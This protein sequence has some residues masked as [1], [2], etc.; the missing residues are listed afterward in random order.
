MKRIHVALALALASFA[1]AASAAPLTFDIDQPHSQVGFSIRHFFSKVPGQFKDFSGTIVMDPDDPLGLFGRGHDP[2]GQHL[3]RQR[4]ARQAPQGPGLLRRGLVPDADLQE[5][6]GRPRGQGQVKVTGDLTMRGV[7]KSVVLDVEFL[8]MGEVGV[9]GQ[10]MGHQG[11]LRR[12]HD[13]QPQGLRHQ[14]EQDARPGRPDARRRRGH[15]PAHR[16]EPE[17]ARQ[18]EVDRPPRSE[19]PVFTT[20]AFCVSGRWSGRL[21]I[22]WPRTRRPAACT[23]PRTSPPRSDPG[24][25]PA[26]TRC[27]RRSGW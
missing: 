1:S 3:H 22:P 19:A 10:S 9:G 25:R 6:E 17:A 20:G 26:R 4:A 13:H 18:E 2:G 5:H 16:G 11:R 8:G 14:L 24:R 15:Q 7:T 27:S 23:G 21:T 12:H